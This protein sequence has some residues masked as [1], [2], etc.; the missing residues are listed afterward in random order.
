MWSVSH[1]AFHVEIGRP[2]G[3]QHA[4]MRSGHASGILE[5]GGHSA[6]WSLNYET[7]SPTYR[8]LP[9]GLYRGALAPT[10]PYSP[11]VD[12]VLSGS[13]A[14]DGATVVVDGVPGQ[15]GHVA[16]SRQPERWA[17]AH[18]SDFLDEEAVLHAITAQGRRGPFTTPYLTFVGVLWQGRW[19]RLSKVSRRRDFGLGNWRV[20]LENRR[21]RLTGRV[22]A[23][24]R[25]LLRARYDDPDGRPRFCHN[26]EIS[27]CRL[28]L[29]ERRAGGFEEVAL[30]ESRGTTHA[31]WAGRTAATRVEHAFV[32]IGGT[33][34]A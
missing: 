6:S 8:L 23:P 33:D 16:G 25:A 2:S 17:W 26:S 30:L 11:N 27:S 9:G 24:P 32:E 18:C 21:Y 14:I 22:E 4:L 13:I 15:Q 19:V 10:R 12:T 7:G 34:P 20:S 3:P 5:G 29:F 31:E 1:D 28:A